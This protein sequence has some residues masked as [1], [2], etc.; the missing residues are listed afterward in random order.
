MIYPECKK[1]LARGSVVAHRQTHNGVGKGGSGQ[2][3][4]EEGM[5]NNPINFRMVFPEK[6]GPRLCPVGG[7]SGQVEMR[8]EMR[9]HF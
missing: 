9:V 2:E 1:D 3:V 8:T 5:G 4:E 7:C 6:S